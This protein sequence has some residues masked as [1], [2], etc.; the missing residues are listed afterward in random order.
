MGN[1]RTE[2]ELYGVQARRDAAEYAN[3]Y[4]GRRAVMVFDVVASRRRKYE[5]RVA[6]M[7]EQYAGDA[8]TLGSLAT[9]GPGDGYGLRDGEGETMRQVAA[10]LLRFGA[11]RELDDEEAIKSWADSVAEFEHAA[12]LDPYV[13][14]VKGIGLA[15][16]AYLRMRCGADAIKPDVRVRRA[17]VRLGFRVPGDEHAVLVVCGAAAVE[18]GVSKLVLDQLLWWS[19]TR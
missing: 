14:A 1:L 8:P 16:F 15:L 5:T 19:D 13:G 10:G 18:L 7:V 17:L 12:K 6:R 2:F 9:D 11:E 4:A 3:V